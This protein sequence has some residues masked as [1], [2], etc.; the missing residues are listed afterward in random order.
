MAFVAMRD[1]TGKAAQLTITE[2]WEFGSVHG[3]GPFQATIKLH[4]DDEYM[5]LELAKPITWQGTEF[6]RLIAATRHA[7]VSFARLVYRDVTCDLL[8]LP[9]EKETPDP[10][11]DTS[12]N[13]GVMLQGDLR[14][15]GAFN[16]FGL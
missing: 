2:P 13:D 4:E 10:L 14:L 11:R 7:G 5:L 15:S 3:C 9:P 16:I 8:M 1:F 6:I 12:A